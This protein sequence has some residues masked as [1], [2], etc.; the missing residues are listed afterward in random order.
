MLGEWMRDERGDIVYMHIRKI[1][2]LR[3]EDLPRVFVR[4]QKIAYVAGSG[5][6][7]EDGVGRDL[8]IC[9]LH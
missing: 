6:D 3:L 8:G 7:S 9:P 2:D 1:Y 4:A 5:F